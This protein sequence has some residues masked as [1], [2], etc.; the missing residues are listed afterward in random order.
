MATAEQYADW[1]VKNADKRG[2][3]EFET[4]A[5]AY[6]QVRAG[7]ASAA[8]K[9]SDPADSGGTLQFGPFDTGIKTSPA[10]ERG[11]AGAGK[12]MADLG[13]G[14]GQLVGSVSR[15]DV[16]ESRKLD[17]PLMNTTGGK[18]GNF[19]GNVAMLAPT[20]LIPGANTVTGAGVIGA[21]AGLLQPSASTG[22]TL[23]NVG[24]GAA[25]GAGGQFAMN[26]LGR[27]AQSAGSELTQGQQAA[28]AAGKS[29]GMRL[30][31]GKASGSAALQKLEAAAESNPMTSSGFDAI[32]QGN[33][34]ALNRAAA[35][36]IG[37]N[38]DE[39]STPV[40]ARA[41]QRIGAVFDSVKD[42]TPVPLDPIN[43]GAKL[44]AIEDDASG[45]LM[46]NNELGQNGLWKRLDKFVNGEGGATREQLR[47][48]SSN[49]GKKAKGEM[50]SPNGD[51][52]LGEALFSAQE[53]VEDAIQ[54]TL[55]KAQQTAY[56]EARG[57]YR[58]LMN[59]T[60][61]TNVTNP[62]SGNVSGKSLATT[63][64]QKDRG[65]FT[66]GR[67]DNDLYNAARFTQAF[68]DI[69][70]N[71][72]TAT[73]SMGAAD[74]VAGLPGN[75]LTRMYLSRPVSAAAGAGA[76]VAGTGARLADNKL[77]RLLAQP[78]GSAGALQ[79]GNALQQ[80]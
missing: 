41:E 65:G 11:L 67:T 50:T 20:A 39:L 5:K 24:L 30:T 43:V 48:L 57:Q 75:L 9:P 73:R 10:I 72:G 51:R 35:K 77:A 64:M 46:G 12:A 78:V 38:A 56:G 18:V 44:R 17:A 58:N 68:P 36:A 59:L 70:G 13:R 8:E 31:P 69:V 61:K 14:A 47:N 4:V 26:K 2:S 23:A 1:I 80:K 45:M 15:S 60:A 25:G 37:E 42:K 21:G 6:Q 71:S 7:S 54:G 28:S 53:I 32:K 19:A 79:L 76:G 22:E 62:S 3:P 66:M 52:A 33:Q 63:L 29:V 40:L 16:E 74:Y 27:L 34:K 49:L 55:T